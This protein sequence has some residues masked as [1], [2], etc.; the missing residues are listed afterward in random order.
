[1]LV[2]RVIQALG[3]GRPMRLASMGV[4]L[5]VRQESFKVSLGMA[6]S[7]VGLRRNVAVQEKDNTLVG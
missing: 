2:L 5:G 6:R 3:A 4:A 7:A 1:M